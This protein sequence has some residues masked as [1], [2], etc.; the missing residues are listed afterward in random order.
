MRWKYRSTGQH[1]WLDEVGVDLRLRPSTVSPN[2][3]SICPSRIPEAH[4]KTFESLEYVT[5][6]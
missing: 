2:T 4:H 3:S 5:E 1:R 6:S